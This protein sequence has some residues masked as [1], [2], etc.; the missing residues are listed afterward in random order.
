MEREREREV[1]V[2][3]VG[4]SWELGDEQSLRERER[5]S[6]K[7]EREGERGGV[8]GWG[9]GI[10]LWSLIRLILKSRRLP[11]QRFRPH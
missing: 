5:D 4:E 7:G 9:V 2:D 8:G 3:L 11:V 6:K 10:Y 1:E